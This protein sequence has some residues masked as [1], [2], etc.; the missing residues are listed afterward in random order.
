M[1]RR[2][3]PGGIL[4]L[5]LA[6]VLLAATASTASA[7]LSTWYCPPLPTPPT[8]LEQIPEGCLGGPTTS[9]D[10]GDRQLGTTSPAQGFALAVYCSPG[11]GCNET[12]LN[13]RISVSGDYAQTNDCPPTL[14]VTTLPQIQGCLITVTFTPTGTG[15]KQ[16][17][18]STGPGGPTVALT[19]TGVTTPTP[20]VLPLALFGLDVYGGKFDRVTRK[21]K[22]TAATNNDST[23]VATGS[24][25]KKTTTQLAAGEQTTIKARLKHPKRVA[26]TPYLIGFEPKPGKPKIK[27]KLA[28]TDEF[29]QTAA[30]EIEVWLS[31]KPAGV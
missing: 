19:G 13:P 9:V 15:P 5:S 30:D 29:G 25:I 24:K 27:I 1:K 3:V 23:L 22:V 6:V 12:P 18:L 14:P 2:I 8:T 21:L 31:G 28:A 4:A 17:T 26:K 7:D 11:G 16:S 20:P 10:F